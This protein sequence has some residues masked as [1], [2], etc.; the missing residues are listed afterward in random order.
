MYP[1]RIL[2]RAK[3]ILHDKLGSGSFTDA[4]LLD[5]LSDFVDNQIAEVRR[6]FKHFGSK[7]TT[8][9]QVDGTYVYSAPTD[10]ESMLYLRKTEGL[11]NTVDALFPVDLRSIEAVGVAF[12]YDSAWK[13]NFVGTD[14]TKDWTMLYTY[15]PV[16]MHTGTLASVGNTTAVFPATATLGTV[17][18]VSDYYN[19]AQL[20]D[21]TNGKVWNISDYDGPT[22][23]A[24]MDWT[25]LTKPSGTP[26]YEILPMIDCDRFQAFLAWGLAMTVMAVDWHDSTYRPKTHPWQAALRRFENYWRDMQ[27]QVGAILPNVED[28]NQ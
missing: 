19:N 4:E 8:I 18:T 11:P 27:S 12:S 24:T 15:K 20:F 16:R 13:L 9:S 1:S 26:N 14:T 23:T 28:E 22:R 2:S 3:T 6:K 25:A 7:T 17:E 5:L 10:L 21:T